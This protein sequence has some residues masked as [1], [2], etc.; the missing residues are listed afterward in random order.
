V[1]RGGAI[2]R[3]RRLAALPAL[4]AASVGLLTAALPHCDGDLIPPRGLTG[5][6]CGRGFV[7]IRGEAEMGRQINFWMTEEDEE[8]L[9]VRLREDD[10]VW[11]PCSLKLGARPKPNELD[12]WRSTADEQW[13]IC[14]RRR[15]WKR[16]KYY[17]IL[18]DPLP[19]S[20]R[21]ALGRDDFTP[22]TRVGTGS[23]PCFEWQTCAR[24]S[25]KIA[26][27]RVYFDSTWLEDGLAM[28]KDEEPT[29]WFDR[30]AAWIRRRGQKRDYPGQYVMP[31]A[32][33]LVSSGRIELVTSS[34]SLRTSA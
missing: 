9:V 13:I 14:I 5:F 23:S 4:D 24:T 28:V 16:L 3:H 32:A 19:Q 25:A 22:W 30:L 29:R 2:W 21:R 31:G 10:I 33:Q 26:R 34:K 17:D 1:S 11:T 18:E 12:A 8:A 20:T 7:V 6:S 27:G 15:D